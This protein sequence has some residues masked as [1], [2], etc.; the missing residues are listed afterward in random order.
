MLIILLDC[1][2]PVRYRCPCR[3]LSLVCLSVLWK[4]AKLPCCYTRFWPP[5]IWGVWFGEGSHVI[6][7]QESRMWQFFSCNSWFTMHLEQIILV[8]SLLLENLTFFICQ[9]VYRVA[10]VF[11]SWTVFLLWSHSVKVRKQGGK[12]YVNMVA[13]RSLWHPEIISYLRILMLLWIR[14]RESI[15]KRLPRMVFQE[16]KSYLLIVLQNPMR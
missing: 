14:M 2:S 8:Q 5:N 11:E 3:W 16:S 12:L 13:F 9:F 4:S 15:Q 10:K 6:L 1:R 7:I